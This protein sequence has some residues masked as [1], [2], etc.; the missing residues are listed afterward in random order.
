MANVIFTG[1]EQAF[2]G[3]SLDFLV[4]LNTMASASAVGGHLTSMSLFNGSFA[5]DRR[6]ALF[7]ITTVDLNSSM[8][9]S[10]RGNGSTPAGTVDLLQVD[11][12]RDIIEIDPDRDGFSQDD[13]LIPQ[14]VE[15]AQNFLRGDDSIRLSGQVSSFWGDYKSV[16]V[17]QPAQMGDDFFE[18]TGVTLPSGA[19]SVSI[20]GDAQAVLTGAT[21]VGG[22]DIIRAYV[23]TPL[24]IFGDFQFVEG[25]A[26]Y[27]ADVIHGGFG[28]DTIYGDAQSS[29]AVGGNDYLVGNSG[30]DS[31]FGGGGN[32]VLEGGSGADALYGGG[33]IDTAAYNALSG[34]RADLLTP[35]NNLGEALGDIYDSIENLGGS[36]HADTLSGNNGANTVEGR[37]G[38]DVLDG[39]GG[40]DTLDGGAGD[41]QMDGGAGNDLFIVAA[42]GDVVVESAGGGTDTVRSYINLTLSA[43]VERLELLASAANGTGNSLNNTLVGNSLNNLLNGAGGNDYMRG[44]AGNDIYIV[45]AAGDF[46]AEDP[47]QGTDTVRSYINWTLAANVE[48]LE[49]QGSGNL[50]GTGNTL[51]NTLV[52]N[53]GA[54]SLSSGNGDDYITGGAGNDTLNGG[55]GNDT[56]VG[57]AGRDILIGG[58][59]SD[60]FDFDLVSHSPA[61]AA[62]RD[63]INGGFS[64]GFDRIDLAT[65]D[66]NALAAGNQA[67]S[68]IGSAAFS[69]VAG[70]LRYTN[71]SG[72]VII[73]ADLNGDSTADMQI[74]VAGTAF[75]NAA[76]FMV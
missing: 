38:N 65:I 14:L 69:G 37:A 32:D 57:G 52:G 2:N 31:L 50:N 26:S 74:L 9:T 36:R 7:D 1:N 49:L 54:N 34:L 3:T 45:A 46:T 17:G 4:G 67:F 48:R 66:A 41:D 47:G 18:L 35:A 51:N 22:D 64:H 58:T 43:E 11:G 5:V 44:G 61:G 71:Y 72:N 33:G 42:A 12:L 73:D 19:F 53:S 75:M 30:H 10:I 25:T 55:A 23:S 70:Q 28:S 16:T 60:T 56:L 29:V 20:F 21:A 39:R 62:S 27:G 13:L 59:G 40:N 76:D 63:S 15:I 6:D 68:F 8:V 24:M